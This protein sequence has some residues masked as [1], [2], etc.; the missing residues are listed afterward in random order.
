MNY[1]T[2]LARSLVEWKARGF[3]NYAFGPVNV[4]YMYNSVDSYETSAIPFE[5]DSHET[6]DLHATCGLMADQLTLS[7]SVIN[8]TDEDPP[9]AGRDLNYDPFQHNPFGRMIK[10]GLTYTTDN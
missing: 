6:H 7:L 4:R 9:F 2:S 1:G 10:V 3:V 5:I 8:L